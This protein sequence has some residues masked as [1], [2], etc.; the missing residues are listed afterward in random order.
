MQSSLPGG[1]AAK[2]AFAFA[3]K[4]LEL[5]LVYVRFVRVGHRLRKRDAQRAGALGMTHLQQQQ[6]Q[7]QRRRWQAQPWLAERKETQKKMR[8]RP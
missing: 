7:Q 8:P 4:C 5:R 1:E 6:Q 3:E 2:L